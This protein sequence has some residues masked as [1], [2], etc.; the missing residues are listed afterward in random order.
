MV[1]D[2]REYIIYFKTIAPIAGDA[3]QLGNQY[4]RFCGH[5]RGSKLFCRDL[6]ALIH[7]LTDLSLKQKPVAS[8]LH[9]SFQPK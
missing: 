9:L 6:C 4:F 2:P 5:T 1:H 8:L 7:S 3:A